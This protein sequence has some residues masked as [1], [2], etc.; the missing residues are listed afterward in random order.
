VTVKVESRLIK[1]DGQGK[2]VITSY[3]IPVATNDIVK[4][5]AAASGFKP[6]SQ[7]VSFPQSST[8]VVFKFESGD[9]LFII[10]NVQTSTSCK[11]SNVVLNAK[12]HIFKGTTANC[13][14]T[15]SSST[16]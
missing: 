12:N 16:A 1:T 10:L 8:S 15:F 7:N 11:E 3:T 14:I 9:D 6:F 2:I 5:E 4:F 13:M